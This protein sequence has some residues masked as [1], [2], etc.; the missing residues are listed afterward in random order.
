MRFSAAILGGIREA[1]GED[2]IVGLAVSADPGS[3]AML[4][5]DGAVRGRRLARRAPAHGLRDLRHRLLL[6]LPPD[7]PAV[8]VRAAARRAVRGGARRA[9]SATR[10]SRPR[11]TSGRPPPPRPCSPP[12]MPTWSA[13]SAARS[14]TRTWS[15]RL[16]PGARTRSGRASRATSCAGAA[17][18]ATTG[19]RAWSTRRPGASGSGAATGS[20]RRRVPRRVLVVGG[21]PAGLETARVAAER[22]H[23]VTLWERGAALG[24]QFRLAGLQPSRGQV[25]DLIAWHGRRLAALGVDV[26]LGRGG[27]GG[28]HRGLRRGRGGRRDRLAASHGPASSGRCRWSTGSAAWTRRTSSRSTTC[29][30]ARRRPASAGGSSSSTTSTTGAVS[31]RRSHLAEAGHETTIVTAATVVAGGLFHSAADGPLRARY[32]KAGGRSITGTAVIG[33]GRRPRDPPRDG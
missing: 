13:S 28:G 6:R 15:P 29:S 23:A 24:G 1:C 11:A 9:S 20:S 21:G 5:V 10:R 32:A 18:R 30:T 16:V 25:T 3:P 14:P 12:A 7:H 22:G 17:A 2:F 26:R 8:A 4:S 31:G 33:V 27:D 19:S